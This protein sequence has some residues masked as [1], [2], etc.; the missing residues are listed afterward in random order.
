[1]YHNQ[2]LGGIRMTLV[3]YIT[4]LLTDKAIDIAK[5]T[6]GL[7]RLGSGSSDVSI[8]Y[9][10]LN[11]YNVTLNLLT[12]VQ[13]GSFSIENLSTSTAKEI[14]REILLSTQALAL[15]G[16]IPTEIVSL[17]HK[18]SLFSGEEYPVPF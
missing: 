9:Q 3:Q 10:E 11:F 1:M 6:N 13:G 5:L 7:Q 16:K 4:G 17:L 2:F 14:E 15:S 18:V 8:I 12:R